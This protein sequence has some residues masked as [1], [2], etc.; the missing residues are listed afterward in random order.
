[1]KKGIRNCWWGVRFLLCL[2]QHRSCEK[3]KKDG[4]V[5][6]YGSVVPFAVHLVLGID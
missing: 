3:V 6:E 1:M 5:N 2:G 4:N